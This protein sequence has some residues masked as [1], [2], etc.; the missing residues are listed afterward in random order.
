MANLPLKARARSEKTSFQKVGRAS[1][2]P[3]DRVGGN[4]FRI[5]HRGHRGHRERRGGSLA[6]ASLRRTAS[7]D[8]ATDLASTMCENSWKGFGDNLLSRRCPRDEPCSSVR[9]SVSSLI[10]VATA[11]RDARPTHGF[12]IRSLALPEPCAQ[13]ISMWLHTARQEPRPPKSLLGVLCDLCG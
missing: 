10:S 1:R 2:P 13:G 11:G 12:S 5:S 3:S 9:S 8:R 6:T 4:L 7:T